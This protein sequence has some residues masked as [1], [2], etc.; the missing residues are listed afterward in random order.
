[1]E[2]KTTFLC[3]KTPRVCFGREERGRVRKWTVDEDEI[4]DANSFRGRLFL[5][6]QTGKHTDHEFK[7]CHQSDWALLLVWG[8][9][10]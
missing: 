10:T 8:P 1:M 5:K 9:V 6:S 7:T 4:L 3:G 2:Q